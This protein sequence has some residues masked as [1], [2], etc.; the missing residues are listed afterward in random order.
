MKRFVVLIVA[1]LLIVSSA[2]ADLADF[3]TYAA[4]F[5]AS[6]LQD[7]AE[8]VTEGQEIKDYSAD[9][10]R[11]VF[12]SESGKLKSIVIVG[13]GDKFLAYCAAAIVQFDESS[14]NRTTNYGNLLSSY[15]LSLADTSGE[16]H[17]GG[18][19]SGAITSIKKDGDQCRFIIL[20]LN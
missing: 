13:I 5:G 14:A 19:V 11:V 6:E 15:L 8:S 2:S 20:V 9:G 12:A 7:G 4:I 17:V 16:E 10:C 1:C 3:N 18:T